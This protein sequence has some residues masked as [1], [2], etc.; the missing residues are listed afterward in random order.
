MQKE[1]ALKS[2]SEIQKNIL[3]TL[4]ETAAEGYVVCDEKGCIIFSN[5][6]AEKLF[7]YSKY[8]LIGKEIELL[9]PDKFRHQHTAHRSNYNAAP[10]KRSMGN[11]LELWAKKKTG[12]CFRVQVSLNHYS[13]NDK[14]FI[15]ALITD[16]TERVEAE[17]R[18]R[19]LNKELEEKVAQRTKEL[20]KAVDALT[21]SQ[22]L[23]NAIA[24]NFPKGTI[25]VFDKNLN[26]IFVEGQELFRYGVTS[27][28]L[29]GTNY[30]ERLAPEIR[31]IIE[32]KLRNVFSGNSLSFEV[33]H[34]ANVYLLNAVPLADSKG[35]IK[36]IL[37]VEKNITQEKKAEVEIKNMLE[38]E[39]HLNELKTRFVSMASHEFR[40]PLSTILSSTAL[41]EKYDALGETEKKLKHLFRIRTSVSNLTSIL[42]DFLSLEKIEEGKVTCTLS[43]FDI[44]FFFKE[45]KEEMQAL[46]KQNQVI[47]CSLNITKQII[48]IDKQLLK[49]V[50]INLVSNAIKYAPENTSIRI[51]VTTTDS[52][53]HVEV[54]DK[55][56]GIPENE[57]AH[58]FERFFR[59]KNSTNIQGTGLGLHIVKKYVDMMEGEISFK[60]IE[61]TGT[62]FYINIPLKHP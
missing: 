59:A 52:Y 13:A 8:E 57:Q 20:D 61:N 45:L 7:G 35:K 38:K 1:Q 2:L 48:W 46:A 44:V 43:E 41:V 42:N 32:E 62:H 34:K 54:A 24:R 30:L 5:T 26:Y 40:T 10:S 16:I 19:Q 9:I 22:Q 29:V 18:I 55:G 51:V 39:K 12:E 60:S 27:K 11:K 4:I 23:Y 37:V 15:L 33:E 25:N 56:I 17:N 28:M 47:D 31:P 53:L 49:N 50:M 14:L 3:H 58:L 36:Q 6:Q 21:E